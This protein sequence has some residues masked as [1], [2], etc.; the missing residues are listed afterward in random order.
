MKFNHFQK[1]GWTQRA[2]C[3]VKEVRQRK[4]N[5]VLCFL[6]VESKKCKLVDINEKKQTYR[7]KE[8]ASKYQWERKRGGAD[9]VRELRGANYYV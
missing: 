5:T 8:Q 7:Y 1:H 6:Q 2:L 3:L 9:R 4:I